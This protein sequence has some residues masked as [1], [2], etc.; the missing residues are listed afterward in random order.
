MPSQPSLFDDDQIFDR[1][2]LAEKLRYLRDRNIFIG[3]S[4]WRYEGWLGQVYT[5]DRYY[6]RG[7]FSKK[8]FHEEC[9][10]EY[11]ETFP[12]VGG[13][14]SFYTIPEPAFWKKLFDAAPRL[15]KWSLKV[16][17][18]FTTPRF[19]QQERYGARRGLAN[20]AFL[21]AALFEAGFLEPLSP[22]LDRIGVLIIEF[23]AFSKASYAD[24]RAFFDDLDDFLQRL[25]KSVRYA[26]EI[27]NEDYLDARYFEVLRANGV[28]HTFSSWARMPSLRKQLLIDEAFTARHV[29][30][31]ALLRPGRA[32]AE[33][34]Q[35]FSPYREVKEEYPSARQA[36]RD[37]IHQS[38]QRDLPA[39]IHVNNRF[40]GN[41]VQTI[42]AVVESE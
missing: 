42:A 21:D 22:Y 38:L 41:A 30:A 9:I 23:G 31:R 5:P 27:R 11:A 14:F 39:Y 29:A 35:L 3:T 28:A 19:S 18:D 36:L 12:V 34:V 32:Y 40:E 4:S 37:L 26:V 7:R 2:P 13:D 10:Q 16:P 24:P 25:P 6:T 1:R 8:K 15:L 20:P 33:A 17:E